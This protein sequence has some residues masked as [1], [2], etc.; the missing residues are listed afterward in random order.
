MPWTTPP[1]FSPGAELTADELNILSDDLNYLK[2]IADGVSI[3]GVIVTRAATQSI[4]TSTSTTVSFSAEVDDY[5]GWWSSGTDIVVPAG[6]IPA[7]FTHILVDIDAECRWAANGTGA[8][9]L[10]IYI[11]GVAQDPGRRMA[12][13]GGGD[14]TDMGI[15]RKFKVAA[16]DVITLRCYQNSGSSLNISNVVF[17]CFRYAPAD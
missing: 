14:S 5:G 2:G 7:G 15:S 6:A 1:T 8:R 16:A 12:A 4:S 17:S 13:V 11:N 10:V 3:N 9:V